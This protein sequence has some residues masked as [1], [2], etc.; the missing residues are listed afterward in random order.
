MDQ[1]SAEAHFTLGR[2]YR[3]KG[4]FEQAITELERARELSH[5]RP[6]VLSHLGNAYALAGKTAKAVSILSQLNAMAR[7]N[8]VSPYHLA[9]VF[10]GLG[11]QDKALTALEAAAS[12]GH[13]SYLA[14]LK[15]DPTFD[16]LHNEP[17]FQ[18]V[19][20]SIGLMP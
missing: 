9:V 1:D 16:P 18:K 4:D 20:M 7:E 10:V 13:S 19:L 3:Q 17:R 5:D 11:E 14:G 12:Q 15:A 6:D 2:A 8:S